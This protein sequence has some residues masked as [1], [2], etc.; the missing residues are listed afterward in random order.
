MCRPISI[1]SLTFF[2]AVKFFMPQNKISSQIGKRIRTLL[3]TKKNWRQ[4]PPA[5]KAEN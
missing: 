1:S 2:P 5:K 4:I 3:K